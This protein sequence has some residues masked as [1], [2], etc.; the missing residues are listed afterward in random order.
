MGKKTGRAEVEALMRQHEEQKQ[1]EKQEL[2]ELHAKELADRD[3]SYETKLMNME[4]QH[5]KELDGAQHRY[6]E[7]IKKA[8]QSVE[9][10]RDDLIRQRQM[11]HEKYI[12]TLRE[13]HAAE[14]QNAVLTKID[15]EEK[16]R[17]QMEEE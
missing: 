10:R 12:G 15:E 14:I 16:K 7:D 8:R 5:K 3:K 1:K 4:A 11:E 17:R 9:L 13:K 6:H 2:M